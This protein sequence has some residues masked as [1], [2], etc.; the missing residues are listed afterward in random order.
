MKY[1]KSAA[2]LFMVLALTACFDVEAHHRR[3]QAASSTTPTV[4]TPAPVPVLTPTPS[5]TTSI[6]LLVPAYFDPT[7]DQA[8]WNTL[9]SAAGMAPLMAV[10]N[11]DNG[12]G[13]SQNPA[14]MSNV[15]AINAAG[16]KVIGYVHTSYGTRPLA[17]VEQD[18]ATYLA[19]Y[20]VQGFFVDEMAS[21][22]S[23]AN[24]SDYGQLAAY[25]RAQAPAA[26]IVANPGGTFGEGFPSNHVADVFID[27][28]D[29]QN[30]TNATAQ[31]S[32]VSAF[33][34]SMFAEIAI[35]SSADQAEVG[36]LVST[37]HVGWVYTT[38]LPLDPNPYQTLPGDFIAEIA[39]L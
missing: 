28:E 21:S 30:N 29:L 5:A 14:Y 8:D 17:D 36:W 2:N 10:M 4:T 19:W 23:A 9:I 24:L 6:G 37:R 34:A 12:P 38:S 26:K 7:V 22:D 32:W 16:G 11:P 3:H 25:I 13:A 39:S 1:Q 35:Q 20:P 27:E 31:A 18:V 33:P 15:N